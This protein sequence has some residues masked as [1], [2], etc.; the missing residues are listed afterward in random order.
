MTNEMMQYTIR[1]TDAGRFVTIRD[2]SK[3]FSLPTQ[4]VIATLTA[5][6]EGYTV[7]F[8]DEEVKGTTV[9]TANDISTDEGSP[10]SIT[11]Q[12]MESD[13][14]VEFHSHGTYVDPYDALIEAIADHIE[15]VADVEPMPEVVETVEEVAK[16]VA[17]RKYIPGTYVVYDSVEAATEALGYELISVAEL[18]KA[19]RTLGYTVNK[20]VKAIGGDRMRFQPRN[21]YWTPVIVGRTRYV[22]KSC[23]QDLANL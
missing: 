22:A 9:V 5:G 23:V 19:C 20:F 15:P 10:L 7:M 3:R 18:H 16:P 8:S 4:E 13:R 17:S 6:I 2:I 21:A 11:Q 12:E 1:R 14:D